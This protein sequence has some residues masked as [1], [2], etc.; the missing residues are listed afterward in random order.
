MEKISKKEV[1][2]DCQELKLA[3]IE[4]IELDEQMIN[5]VQLQKKARY[6]LNKAR[7]IL[8]FMKIT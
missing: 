2:E 7:E 6:R 8:H 5:L 1:E 4:T 3:L